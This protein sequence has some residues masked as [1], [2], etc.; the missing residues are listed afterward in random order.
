MPGSICAS[1]SVHAL[2][3]EGPPRYTNPSAPRAQPL[4]SSIGSGQPPLTR[5]RRVRFPH[6]A[7]KHFHNHLEERCGGDSP[8]YGFVNPQG[9]AAW[10]L[11][12]AAMPPGFVYEAVATRM[13]QTTELVSVVVGVEVFLGVVLVVNAP[14]MSSAQ[15]DR[16]PVGSARV[17]ASCNAWKFG[18]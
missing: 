8:P 11:L 18:F 1:R 5:Q 4:R 10:P 16:M 9:M 14:D 12:Q 17:I 15:A 2:A 3:P 6:G 7:P 13:S